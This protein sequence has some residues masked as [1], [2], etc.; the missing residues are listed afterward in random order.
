MADIASPIKTLGAF[1]AVD[2]TVATIGTAE[3]IADG[4][5]K[6]TMTKGERET[7]E[8]AGEVALFAPRIVPGKNDGDTAGVAI[9]RDATGRVLIR[10]APVSVLPRV[11]AT[12][13]G[14][15]DLSA[16]VGD[17][18]LE[19]VVFVPRVV[20]G[21]ASSRR[22]LLVD[23]T[24]RV[25]IWDRPQEVVDA[26]ADMTARLDTALDAKG[27]LLQPAQGLHLL[28]WTRLRQRQ[29]DHKGIVGLTLTAGGSGYTSAPNV[30]FGGGGANAQILAPQA[31]ASISGGAVTSLQLNYGGAKRDA[32]TT[33]TLSGGGG[34]GATA[35]AVMPQLNI[36]LIGDS[37]IDDISNWDRIF[38][39]Q[40]QLRYGFGGLG[41]VSLAS[42]AAHPRNFIYSPTGA[43]FTIIDSDN[44]SPYPTA[45]TYA[46]RAT[47]AGSYRQFTLASSA[48]RPSS[49]KLF[50]Y[51]VDDATIR[52]R[53]AA[54]DSW[55]S[56]T[57]S[58]TGNQTSAL[59]LTGMPATGTATDIRVE[60]LTSTA[61]LN[62]IYFG[63][64]EPG[65]IVNKLGNNGS[66]AK[67]WA[68]LDETQFVSAQAAIPT[69]LY[70]ICLGTNDKTINRTVEQ[71]VADMVTI[72]TRL[73]MAHPATTGSNAQ[74]GADIVIL[75]PPDI[76]PHASNPIADYDLAIRNVAASLG[77]AVVSM[78]YAFGE[79]PAA[80][81]G[82]MDGV[83]PGGTGYHPSDH[84]GAYLAADL[85]L[86]SVFN[87]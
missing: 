64:A 36:T 79:S 14:L 87:I 55:K 30:S 59:D 68:A 67:E 57:L 78:R 46:A 12:E 51:G 10:A 7:L 83:D 71:Y 73:R 50:Y 76:V 32:A 70:V 11:A 74:P 72:V 66:T 48:P 40:M 47:V 34:S 44:V 77:V 3:Q 81:A 45:D 56:A 21:K 17:G 16:L 61:V 15:A 31:V 84:K 20:P 86:R 37:Y 53:W 60:H 9:A 1:P 6:V 82:W 43:G 69:D 5:T 13:L 52:Y 25:L 80:V 42:A 62:A 75:T 58:G 4:E 41:W 24:G 18:P 33:V 54:S 39:E 38:T 22:P 26:I 19:T 28:K 8:L 65:V 35:V 49:A 2:P 27:H 29:V 23:A 85:I 63:S